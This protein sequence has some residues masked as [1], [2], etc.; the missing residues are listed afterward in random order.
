MSL[1]K[2]ETLRIPHAISVPQARRAA[3]VAWQEYATKFASYKPTCEWK[4]NV[5]HV[6]FKVTGHV[7]RGTVA[8]E[9]AAIEI[10]VTFPF[11]LTPYRKP[12]I[13]A[14]G[15]EVRKRLAA[16]PQG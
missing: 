13:Q 7:A 6:S 1:E 10:K 14:I 16:P 4:G 3:E 8:I 12:A 9:P 15:D 11:L 2:T 5:A